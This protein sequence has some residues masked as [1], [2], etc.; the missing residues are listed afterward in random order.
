MDRVALHN[1]VG[2]ILEAARDQIAEDSES[3]APD[4]TSTDGGETALADGFVYMLHNIERTAKN[5]SHAQHEVLKK[6]ISQTLSQSF[7]LN[8][9]GEKKV[10]AGVSDMLLPKPS[11]ELAQKLSHCESVLEHVKSSLQDLRQDPYIAE[12]AVENFIHSVVCSAVEDMEETPDGK[13]VL[14]AIINDLEDNSLAMENL[15]VACANSVSSHLQASTA[16]LVMT[17]RRSDLGLVSTS[18]LFE[19]LSHLVSIWQASATP[20]AGHSQD[21]A[22]EMAPSNSRTPHL[23][24][25][26]QTSL[27]SYK[28]P[29]EVLLKYKDVNRTSSLLLGASSYSSSK[30]T[31]SAATVEGNEN[32]SAETTSTGSLS[33]QNR[34]RVNSLIREFEDAKC[35]SDDS[36]ALSLPIPSRLLQRILQLEQKLD[37]MGPHHAVPLSGMDESMKKPGSPVSRDMQRMV[38]P[39]LKCSL[40]LEKLLLAENEQ[41]MYSCESEIPDNACD[42]NLTDHVTPSRLYQKIQKREKNKNPD[43]EYDLSSHVTPSVLHKKILNRKK[44][45]NPEGEYDLSSYVTPSVLHKKIFNREKSDHQSADFN[46][47]SHVTPSQ[48]AQK[49]KNREKNEKGNDYKLSAHVTPSQLHRK[50]EDCD[51]NRKVTDGDY[52]LA[53]H[54]TPSHLHQKI[55]NREK[56]KGS[57]DYDLS[58]HVTPSKLYQMTSDQESPVSSASPATVLQALIQQCDMSTQTS[59]SALKPTSLDAKPADDMTASVLSLVERVQ[60]KKVTTPAQPTLEQ[61]GLLG[62]GARGEGRRRQVWFPHPGSCFGPG[63]RRRRDHFVQHF[64]RVGADFTGHRWRAQP[65]QIN[66]SGSHSGWT[67][68]C[69]Q[70]IQLEPQG[71][72]PSLGCCHGLCQPLWWRNSWTGHFWGGNPR[73][74]GYADWCS[75]VWVTH[76]FSS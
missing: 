43:D 21:D 18:H 64:I 69:P 39:D 8:K 45:E 62:G 16:S 29:S 40:L 74:C 70:P 75:G 57:T 67:L 9:S 65:I 20:V 22:K 47:E 52:D 13:A 58:D 10:E 19:S 56:N 12:G 51:T 26:K 34:R 44:N 28:M 31:N 1:F 55:E 6:G 23:G 76:F 38:E 48:L 50:M 33:L 7:L 73:L 68:Q 27:L 15:I 72:Q 35:V 37:S 24:I 5:L 36:S 60:A 46:L 42:Y 17:E 63:W 59:F 54:V 61:V 41:S 30:R 71:L 25:S 49:I 14:T 66:H 53:S 3:Q 2:T 4:T 32:S 11:K